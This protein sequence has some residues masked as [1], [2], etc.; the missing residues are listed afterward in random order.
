MTVSYVNK[1]GLFSGTG[2]LVVASVSGVVANDLILLFVESANQPIVA[3]SGYTEVFG[4][5]IATGTANTS[6]GVALQAF[7]RF[8]VGSDSGTTVTDSGDHTTA[9]K[10]VYRGVD[11]ITPFDVDAVRTTKAIASTSSVFPAITTITDNALIVHASALN[12]DLASNTTTGTATNAN[13]TSL[14]ERHDQTVTT[15]FG[16]GLVILDGLLETAG[17]SGDTTATVTSTTQVYLTIALRSKISE[18]NSEP[19]EIGSDAFTSAGDVVVTGSFVRTETGSDTLNSSGKVLIR[20]LLAATEV[21]SDVIKVTQEITG[22]MA[23]VESGGQTG[24]GVNAVMKYY[25]GTA[26]A[27]LYKDPTV[28]T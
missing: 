27:I 10:V 21:G 9:I 8:T 7:Y 15:G 11:T 18:G 14:T 12:L 19:T 28:Y 2:N 26:W 1:S 3:P 5:P 6:S 4:S 13:L 17:D 24:F 20:G 25:T 22:G 23:A 16:G